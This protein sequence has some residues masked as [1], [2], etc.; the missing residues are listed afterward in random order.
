MTKKTRKTPGTG[1]EAINKKAGGSAGRRGGEVRG[2]GEK[3]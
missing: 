1:A 3:K 2:G